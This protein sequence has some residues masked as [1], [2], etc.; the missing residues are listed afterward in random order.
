MLRMTSWMMGNTLMIV[1]NIYRN[2]HEIVVLYVTE[3]PIWFSSAW[4]HLLVFVL[5]SVTPRIDCK[6]FAW[7]LRKIRIS[8]LKKQPYIHVISFAWSIGLVADLPAKDLTHLLEPLPQ[9]SACLLAHT[10]FICSALFSPIA[11]DANIGKL[12]ITW[13]TLRMQHQT[14]NML[15]SPGNTWMTWSGASAYFYCN[16]YWTGPS[17]QL[18]WC[19]LIILNLVDQQWNGF[20]QHFTICFT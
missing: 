9:A 10:F 19:I 2:L 5:N 15:N 4:M 6:A 7:A 11:A 8:T 3:S 20:S 1:S 18:F 16:L 13:F 12:A 14:R 17:Y